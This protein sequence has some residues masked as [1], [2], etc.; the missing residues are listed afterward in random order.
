VNGIKVTSAL[1]SENDIVKV[2][3]TPVPWM[4]YIHPRP[5]EPILPFADTAKHAGFWLRFVAYMLDSII[6]GFGFLIL[7]LVYRLAVGSQ[8]NNSF[9]ELFSSNFF[10]KTG[11]DVY[12]ASVLSPWSF[13]TTPF[14]YLYYIIIVWLYFAAMESSNNQGTLGKMALSL[15]VTD[16]NGNRIS[17]GRATGRHFAKFLSSLTLMIGYMLAGWTKYKQALHDLIAETLVVR[18]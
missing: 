3:N 12:P 5:P 2:G 16:I 9:D 11:F 1:L 7:I 15:K 4:N 13:F 17:F 6:L 10:G 18:K 8:V 14:Y